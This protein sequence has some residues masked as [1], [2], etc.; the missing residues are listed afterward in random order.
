MGM[1]WDVGCGRSY[2]STPVL[3]E[4]KG[5][6]VCLLIGDRGSGIGDRGS[7]IGPIVYG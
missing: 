7:G 2:S 6:V 1:V 4:A 5:R 3:S